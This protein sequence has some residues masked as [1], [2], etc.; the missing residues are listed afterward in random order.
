MFG[1]IMIIFKISEITQVKLDDINAPIIVHNENNK[2]YNIV[3]H[4]RL[5][6]KCKQLSA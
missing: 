2:R 1:M 4:F 5:V 3:N 6:K